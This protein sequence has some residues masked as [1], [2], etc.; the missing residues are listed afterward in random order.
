MSEL[1][2]MAAEKVEITMVIEHEAHGLSLTH[3]SALGE[4]VRLDGAH[5]VC[6]CR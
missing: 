6:E 4:K 2:R 3:Q 5:H 1:A